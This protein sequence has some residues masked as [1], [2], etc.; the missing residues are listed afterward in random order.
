MVNKTIDY[1]N[2]HVS[3]FCSSTQFVNMSAHYDI[4]EAYL[5]PGSLIL[6]AGCG[7]GRDSR[8]FNSIGHEVIA[9]DASEEMVR[10]SSQVSGIHVIKSTF[11]DFCTEKVF[12]GIWA[13]ASLLHLN[14]EILPSVLKRFA[15]FLK[16]D[17]IFYMSFKHGDR[18]YIKDDRYFNCYDEKSFEQLIAKLDILKI[19]NLYQ[20][21]DARK[22]RE[23]EYWLN[24]IV[25]K[26]SV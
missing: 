26:C 9:F 10:L 14:R 19:V 18:T 16:P 17:G 7:V 24:A 11:E 2:K 23:D 6:D 5:K 4:F 22:G 8:Y 13:C 25:K 20:S 12:D 3:D 15:S 21:S 1:Y